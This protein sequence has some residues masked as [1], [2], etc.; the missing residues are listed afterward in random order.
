[1]TMQAPL[2]R[3]LEEI[4]RERLPRI[5]AAGADYNDV[6]TVLAGTRAMDQWPGAWARLAEMHETL[7]REAETKGALVTAGE[8]FMRAAL[9]YHIGQ[10]VL[11]SDPAGK[12]RLQTAQNAAYLRAAPHLLPP[13]ERIRIPAEGI[14]YTANLRRPGGTGPAPLVLLT[15]GADS[16]KEEFHSLENVFLKRGLATC[17]YDGPGQGLTRAGATLRPDW[18]RVVGRLIDALSRRDDI[19]G[20]RI[21][22]W[23]RSFGGYA[24]LRGAKDPRVA[25]C[26]SIGGF[27]DLAAIWDRMPA[28]TH[29]SLAFG[30]GAGGPA[31]ARDL[32]APYTLKGHLAEVSCPVLVVH[33][34]GDTV[35]PVA[36][37]RRMIEE[38]GPRGELL[39]YDD[40][41]HV[42]DNIPYK[43][44]PAMADWLAARLGATPAT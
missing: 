37:S 25:A 32:V 13:A 41:N 24:V 7:G 31:G 20:D 36:E 1:M 44:R 6:Q 10:S 5:L 26:V 11:F 40:G 16:T 3:M 17:S 27:H 22:L 8:A 33:S 39:V 29:E 9:Y 14:D 34:G 28:S 19:D 15:P 23:G 21:A 12:R 18:E 35:C 43:V 38:L 30:L 4:L 42:C 2:P